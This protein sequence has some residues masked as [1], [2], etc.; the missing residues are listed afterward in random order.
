MGVG[1]GKIRKLEGSSSII[2]SVAKGNSGIEFY[3][4]LLVGEG[5]LEQNKTVQGD[6]DS[7]WQRMLL[8]FLG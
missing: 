7:K 8:L 5:R 2:I 3:C 6:D 1:S 4:F